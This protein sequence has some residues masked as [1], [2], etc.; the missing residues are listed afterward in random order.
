M[1]AIRTISAALACGV[2]ML[3]VA[4]C[5]TESDPKGVASKDAVR[6][7]PTAEGY[8]AYAQGGRGGR[9]IQ[10]TNLEDFIPGEEAVIPGSLR[11]ACMAEGPRIIVFR[12][13]GTIPL[14]APLLITEPYC[15]IAGQT[16]PGDGICVRDDVFGV[17]GT[18]DIIIRYLRVRC[19]PGRRRGYG[20][21]GLSVNDSSNVIIDHCSVT[22]GVDEVVCITAHPMGYS[23]AGRV[24]IE[25][26]DRE[27]A[28]TE[29]ITVQWSIVAE[30]LNDSTHTHGDHSKGLMVAYGPTRV[31]LHHN[32]IAHNTDRNPYIPSEGEL[33]FIVDVRN[34]LV[35]NWGD[36][37]GV[38][39]DKI[40]HNG[41]LNF[42]GNRYISGPSTRKP[43][44]SL[45]LGV[46]MPVFL[47]DNLGAVRT[48]SS[49]PQHL[50]MI[51]DGREVD[52][53]FDCPPVVTHSAKDLHRIVLPYVGATLPQ[54]DTA[55]A[56][57]VRQVDERTGRII[58]HPREVGGWPEL[59]GGTPPPD[60]DADG[61][62]DAWETSHGFDPNDAADGNGDAD[63]DGYTNIE[64]YLNTTDPRQPEDHSR[65]PAQ[66]PMARAPTP[67]LYDG[68]RDLQRPPV[69]VEAPIFGIP[70]LTDITI[71]GDL[72]DWGDR[73]LWAPFL[74]PLGP[75]S[76]EDFDPSFRLGWADHGL[77]I[78][79]VVT[80]D[81]I[82][83]Q[84]DRQLLWEGHIDG[85]GVYV[86]PQR[87]AG[88][89][90]RAVV[91]PRI[92]HHDGTPQ[93][94]ARFIEDDHEDVELDGIV[95]AGAR[96]ESG[97]ALEMFVPW[98]AARID[99]A[100][101]KEL[102]VQVFIGDLDSDGWAPSLWYPWAGT[103]TKTERSQRVRLA[104]TA[105]QPFKAIGRAAYEDGV[106]YRVRLFAVR[107]LAGKTLQIADGYEVLAETQ[108]TEDTGRVTGQTVVPALPDSQHYSL[109]LLVVD[110]EIVGELILPD[111]SDAN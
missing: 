60:T 106:G 78:A 28:V 49:D 13:S 2:M 88:R 4:G 73:G 33:P 92:A 58:S 66:P 65:V 69:F 55:D 16:A 42:V 62:P 46:R 18:H 22:W 82:L 75:G 34:N 24:K 109:L 111:P 90:L 99:P 80:D 56:R 51:G 102:G 31:T 53:A 14:K 100:L 97:Y 96:T 52:E 39:Y 10:V 61:M 9:V 43:K 23:S 29:N 27:L 1:N 105:D 21:D 47:R 26:F 45:V 25:D 54:R 95:A 94:L 17:E 93:I 3:A 48:R 50:A 44:P 40:N 103:L 7:F 70:R 101:G 20:P 32:L 63:E 41:R 77:L 36:T 83:E 6:A 84:T 68:D 79:A 110:D 87:G 57:L 59:A 98:E 11:A 85:M 76:R 81:E 37:P 64:E 86:I 5:T 67:Q 104:E 74:R 38:A 107:D 108:L 15:T 89:T 91:S 30:G 12:T 8:G 19:G 72:S 35:Y 71:D